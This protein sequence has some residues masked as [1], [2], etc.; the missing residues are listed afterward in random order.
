MNF[1]IQHGHLP[2]GE[3]HDNRIMGSGNNGHTLLLIEL[4]Q[5]FQQL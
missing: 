3:A 4:L 1:A 2:G 5:H